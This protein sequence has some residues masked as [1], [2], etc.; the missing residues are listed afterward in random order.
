M[1]TLGDSIAAC[2][3]PGFTTCAPSVISDYLR[4]R[5]A[6][7]LEYRSL[8]VGGAV[9]ADILGQASQVPP[10]PGHLLVWIY[11]GG[12][13][14]L[15]C[16]Q[17]DLP[18]TQA[19]VESLMAALPG[20]WSEIFA[21]FSDRQRFPDGVTFM[22]N[23]QYSPYDQCTHP[24]GPERLAYAEAT[25]QRFNRDIIM[26]PALERGDA[27][28]VDQYPD[29]LGH[30]DNANHGGCPYCSRDDNSDWLFDGTHPHVRGGQHI[31]DKWKVAIDR[32]YGSCP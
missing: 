28:A 7:D 6:P 24:L 1:V 23:T 17:A 22:L 12:N 11:V 9:T 4:E 26:Q 16:A 15:R 19:C 5:Y 8:A 21:Y 32:L 30:A 29:F 20:R 25:I 14:L 13:D 2:F 31:A 10:G 27:V 3:I 18:K